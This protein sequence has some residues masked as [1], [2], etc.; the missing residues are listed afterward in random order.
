M[1]SFQEYLQHKGYSQSVIASHH[2]HLN[3]YLSWCTSE[4]TEPVT[5][6]HNDL[7]AYIKYLQG[8]GVKQRTVQLYINS[9]KHYFNWQISRNYMTANPCENLTIQGIKRKQLYHIL[10]PLELAK[11]YDQYPLPILE[12]DNKGRFQ[13]SFA[14]ALRNK[15]VIGLLIWQGVGTG[16]LKQLTQ[17]DLQLREGRIH[18]PGGR[19]SNARTLALKSGQIL[20]LMQYN[21][22]VR[23]ELLAHTGKQTDKL[24]VSTGQAL[25][26]QNVMRKLLKQLQVINSNISSLQQIR[27][28]AITHWLKHYNLRQV[29]YMA[30]HR[31]V[32]ST[33]SYY[34]NDL[35]DLQEDI[36]QYHPL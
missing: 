36:N 14:V 20:D 10:T 22:E 24:I 6:V 32:S 18:I 3:Y 19:R 29:Q 30:G 5:T 9:L 8:R 35:E 21:L 15:V 1:T 33:E 31:H 26:I 7:V 34:I 25:D 11:L 17:S 13:Q 12:A 28:S 27:T 4:N 23:K 2:R 16:E